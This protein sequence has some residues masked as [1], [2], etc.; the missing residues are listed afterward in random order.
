LPR[1]RIVAADRQDLVW[2]YVD[3]PATVGI[4]AE[5]I[6]RGSFGGFFAS[7]PFF[8]ANGIEQIETRDPRLSVVKNDTLAASLSD[9]SRTG[10]EWRVVSTHHV[11]QKKQGSM[12]TGVCMR[13]YSFPPKIWGQNGES[14][15]V[16]G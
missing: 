11:S 15:A 4:S 5:W 12:T 16:L 8:G 9:K 1:I 2:G 14:G 7:F 10:S 6:L 3:N 13:G